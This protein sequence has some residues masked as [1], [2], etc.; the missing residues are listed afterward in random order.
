M[1]KAEK[2]ALKETKEDEKVGDFVFPEHLRVGKNDTEKS[3]EQKRKKVK[4]LKLTY[5]TQV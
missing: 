2:Q 1:Q 3:R 5:K 4:A